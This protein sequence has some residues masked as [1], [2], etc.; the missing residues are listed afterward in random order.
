MAVA[1]IWSGIFGIEQIGIHE[2]FTDLGG[3]SLMAL[4]ILTRLRTQCRVDITLRD[5]FE[6]PTIAL[7]SAVV[8]DRMIQ[9]LEN[10]TDEEVRELIAKETQ[11]HD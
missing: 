1:A 7:L 5:F 3:H 9:D 11:A 2:R 10:L 8:R 4:Q 6:A